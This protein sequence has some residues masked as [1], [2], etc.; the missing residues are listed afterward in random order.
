MKKTNTMY[1]TLIIFFSLFYLPQ[2][3]G[4]ESRPFQLG[5][6]A[7]QMI[8]LS[9]ES[10]RNGTNEFPINCL[11]SEVD[12]I[13][14]WPEYLGIPY[15]EFA[16][17]PTV[18]ES[19]PWTI[20]MRELIAAAQVGNRP[21]MLELGFVRTGMVGNAWNNNGKL[22]VNEGW[23][24]ICY[25]FSQPEAV[26]VGDAYVNYTKWMAAQFQPAYLV[27]FIEANL[28]YADCGGQTPSW[29]A[30]VAIQQRAYFAAKLEV[31]NVPVFPSFHLETL[32]GNEVNGWNENQYQAIAQME[33][34]RFGVSIY[35]FGLRRKDGHFVTPYDLPPD[36]IV[37]PKLLHPF[38]QMVITETGWNN[39]PIAIGDEQSCITN[40][41]YSQEQFAADYLGFVFASAH[42]GNFDIVN[43]WSFRDEIPANV[44]STCY[45]RNSIPFEQCQGEPW[46]MVINYMKDVTYQQNSELFSE[47]VL[48]AFDAMGLKQNDGTPRPLLMNKWLEQLSLPIQ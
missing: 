11:S 19:H 26:A 4:Y 28:Y 16:N 35:P 44:L 29:A 24:P 27:N 33:R 2:A 22:S 34:D 39:V 36:Y 23:A 17:G 21:I 12:V 5:A 25:D 20:K 13:T 14:I 15:E 37:R 42:Y 31:P 9:E 1:A 38:E 43:W 46:C 47:L 6:T 48:K 18:S 8:P 45:V 10:F 41:P 40:F 30:L 3:L 7:V 32:Y